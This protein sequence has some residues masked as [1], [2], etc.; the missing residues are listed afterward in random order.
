[1]GA[2]ISSNEIFKKLKLHERL[3][4]RNIHGPIGLKVT[5]KHSPYASNAIPNFYRTLLFNIINIQFLMAISEVVIVVFV[6]WNTR[7]ARTHLSTTH[8]K[9]ASPMT[10]LHILYSLNINL[11]DLLFKTNV[12]GQS[13]FVPRSH[14]ILALY[15]QVEGFLRAS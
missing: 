5:I 12:E 4:G 3:F 11:N 6:R 13:V 14:R 2:M 15:E 1:M 9:K 8:G 7:E 10:A